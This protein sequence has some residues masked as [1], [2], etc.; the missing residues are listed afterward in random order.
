MELGRVKIVWR[1][2]RLIW[3]KV[4]KSQRRADRSGGLRRGML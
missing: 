3:A 2:R 1:N 4:V